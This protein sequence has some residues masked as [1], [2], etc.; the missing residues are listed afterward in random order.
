[1]PKIM[2]N[3]PRYLAYF[4]PPAVVEPPPASWQTG[5][6]GGHHPMTTPST[7]T[8]EASAAAFLRALAGRN[9]SRQTQKACRIDLAQF[10][11][12]LAE[13]NGVAETPAQV[14][15]LDVTEYLAHLAGRG[16]SGVTRARK[17]AA[18][19]EYFRY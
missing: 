9:L 15:R 8:L 1:M 5:G 13:T 10:L 11:A 7:L 17:L 16:L 4:S 19:R 18:L 2:A 3:G 6:Q 12:W 14:T